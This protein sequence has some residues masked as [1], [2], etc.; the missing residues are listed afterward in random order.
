MRI[1]RLIVLS[2]AAG[3]ALVTTTAAPAKPSANGH[4]GVTVMTRN[5]YLGAELT[6][7]MGAGSVPELLAA[8]SEVWD[9]VQDTD[10]T[11]RVVGIADEIEEAKPDLIGLQEAALWRID[12]PGNGPAYPA[13]EVVYDFV[14]ILLEELDS[15][16]LRYEVA[17]SQELFDVELPNA[18]W[19]DIRFTDRDVILVRRH[20]KKKNGRGPVKITSTSMGV[21]QA[22]AAVPVLGGLIPIPRGWVAVDGKLH[23]KKFRFVNAHLEDDLPPFIPFQEAQAQELVDGPL[24]TNRALICLGDFNSDAIVYRTD[25]YDILINSGLI[26]TWTTTGGATW[27]HDADLMNATPNLTQRLDLILHDGSFIRRSIDVVGDEV[28]D[29]VT[30][31]NLWPSDHAGVIAEFDFKRP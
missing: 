3:L 28:S 24:V 15:R 7:V 4:R 6:P 23:G 21:F 13:T 5:L 12:S 27:G 10:F 16:K 9:G 29:I 30:P 18:D 1:S 11:A 31:S 20:G 22:K 25:S 14:E 2:V 26:D 17:V 8:V 19:D